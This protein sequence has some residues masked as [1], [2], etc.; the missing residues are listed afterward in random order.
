MLA[1]PVGLI[2]G[3]HLIALASIPTASSLL[4]RVGVAVGFGGLGGGFGMPSTPTDPLVNLMM[5]SDDM[6]AL[7]LVAAAGLGAILVTALPV[8]LAPSFA[9]AVLKTWRG[10][11]V[12]RRKLLFWTVMPGL[13]VLVVGLVLELAMITLWG[14]TAAHDAVLRSLSVTVDPTQ[15]NVPDRITNS[16]QRFTPVL[17]VIIPLATAAVAGVVVTAGAAAV[18]GTE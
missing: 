13:S 7:S 1:I 3:V 5:F 12:P 11:G 6:L 9:N 15:P 18:A 2:M 4:Y 10:N 14:M 8:L 17:M 16:L